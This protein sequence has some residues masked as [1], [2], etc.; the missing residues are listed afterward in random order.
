MKVQV[1][2]IMLV[3]RIKRNSEGWDGV[4]FW[5]WGVRKRTVTAVSVGGPRSS[6]SLFDGLGSLW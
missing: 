6:S 5:D 4:R 3:K 2:D 1:T